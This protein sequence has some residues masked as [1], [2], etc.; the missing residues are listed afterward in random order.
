MPTR[1]SQRLLSLV[2]PVIAL[3]GVGLSLLL[4]Q[5]L[6]RAQDRNLQDILDTRLRVYSKVL[7]SRTLSIEQS[8]QRMGNWWTVLQR[9]PRIAWGSDAKAILADQ[10]MLEEIQWVDSGLVRRW[11]V[12]ATAE[13]WNV[14]Q[15]LV[16]EQLV[17]QGI[18]RDSPSSNAI[19]AN[20]E[21]AQNGNTYADI[22][23]PLWVNDTFDGLVLAK[24]NLSQLFLWVYDEAEL[25]SAVDVRH[26][27]AVIFSR[28]KS[29]RA[30]VDDF[31][32]SS[33]MQLHNL[34]IEIALQPTE[35]FLAT[36]K[37]IWPDVVFGGALLFTA[38]VALWARQWVRTTL[39]ERDLAR[40]RT[41]LRSTEAIARGHRANLETT[42]EAVPFGVCFLDLDLRYVTINKRLAEFNG[43]AVEDHIGKTMR[44]I[45]PKIAEKMEPVLD[46]VLK[47]G[48][49][50]ENF[51]IQAAHHQH[52]DTQRNWLCSFLPARSDTGEMIGIAI[53]ILDITSLK[54]A[55]SEKHTLT[56]QLHQTQ[57]TEA[58]GRLTG[59]IAHDFN[60]MLGVIL[61]TLEFVSDRTTDDTVK[62]LIERI[63]Q[64]AE[65]AGELTQRLLAFARQQPLN[66]RTVDVGA[67]IS[68]L[69]KLLTRSIDA[70]IDIRCVLP[71]DLWKAEVDPSQL[72][73]AVLNLAI[74]ARD[75]MP[76]GGK[77]TIEAWNTTLDHEY[78]DAHDEVEAGD[79]VVVCVSDTGTGMSAATIAK[80][81]EPF[82]TTK[83]V[84]KGS[85]LGL[86]MV[87]GFIKQS[88][89][90]IQIYSELGLGTVVK[91]Y[92]PRAHVDGSPQLQQHAEE[93]QHGTEVVLVVEDEEMMR[94][95]AVLLLESL[96]YKTIVAHNGVEAVPII[97][98]DQHIDVLFTDIVMPGGVD[99]ISL[100]ETARQLRP[101]MPVIYASGYT[102]NAITHQGRLPANTHF[103]QKPYRR[104]E[105]AKKFRE[106]I[107][108]QNT[109]ATARSS[110]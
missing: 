98:S 18:R 29:D 12:T 1:W 103:L 86:S 43:V 97:E 84:G 6:H 61:G 37:S 102:D 71:P 85:G 46:Y 40:T 55:E 106:V 14:N 94:E 36:S 44:Q 82:F 57:K 72:E 33:Q 34:P 65:R 35:V 41:A 38:V 53:S 59:G 16:E 31:T 79:Y 28:Q 62:P 48:T 39:G 87:H 105:L 81:F 74:N 66:P 56:E 95:T 30:R 24:L 73:S 26:D 107:D 32:S 77:L 104:V 100:G 42:Y 88:K 92:V 3:L 11:S 101:A 45:R 70:T 2:A 63:R 64:A 27:G 89:G 78:A 23:V 52:R 76:S 15:P 25:I 51:E 47:H 68:D 83:E 7:A 17:A 90:H 108:A 110:S 19:I 20:V 109:T 69:A 8:L 4:W 10:P 13:D 5:T 91:L 9:T 49:P 75:A 21:T 80:V 58:L 60:N 50:V 93:V 96:G 67:L 22:Y 99:G 54:E